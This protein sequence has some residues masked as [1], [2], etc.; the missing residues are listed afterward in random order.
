MTEE[1]ILCP[2][3]SEIY[4]EDLHLPLTLPRCGHVFCRSCLSGCGKKGHFPCPTCR[5]RHLKPPVAQ[6]PP[7][8]D[9][10]TQAELF[11][12]STLGRCPSHGNLQEYWCRQCQDPLCGSC[13]V[14]AGHDVV[15][16]KIFLTEKKQEIKDQGNIIMQ[17]VTEEKQRILTKVKNCSLQ[18]LKTC[19]VS[20]VTT[21]SGED[22]KNIMVESKKTS[23]IKSVLGNLK[24]MKSILKNLRSA[25][26][27][28][29]TTDAESDGEMQQRHRERYKREE[30]HPNKHKRSRSKE[31]VRQRDKSERENTTCN[32]P[33][34]IVT[35]RRATSI[36]LATENKN[37]NNL[38]GSPLV[39]L[40]EAN[41]WPLKCCV[42]SENGKRAD[43]KWEDGRLHLYSLTD[44]E[45]D[46]HFMI[47]MAV[48]QT[49]IPKDHPEVFMDIK[50]GD[51]YLGRVYIRLWGH[52]RRAHNFLAMCMGT[53]GPSYRGCRFQ[54]V[55][56]RGVPGECLHG[57]VYQT[58]R[59][60][61]C[62]AGVLKD[63][64]W[65]G[66]FRKPMSKGLVVGAG[67]GRPDRDACFDICTRS[68]PARHFACPF[69]E[70]ISGW[71]VIMAIVDFRP[72]RQVFMTE[73]GV[74][75]P[76]QMKGT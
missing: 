49:L 31:S 5:K 58:R 60:S 55:F 33:K 25:A 24:K 7:N 70:V 56:A 32:S 8:V 76:D 15:K 38:H 4:D 13:E 39:G 64:E 20:T 74:I 62:A 27:D 68:N 45:N 10:L 71:D 18:L 12:E 2:L 53:H 16:T 35:Q 54:E 17:N 72:V 36:P 26:A 51:R 46:A 22:I 19:Q 44:Q 6:I 66:K 47:K 29:D 14:S 40:L 3:C 28:D 42:Y 48:L 69:G 11:R 37:D 1:E 50:G 63:L 67:S 57:G 34:D 75:I 52:L 21:S 30:S 23:D 41:I 9:V 61:E 43:L 59:G 65:E 73:V